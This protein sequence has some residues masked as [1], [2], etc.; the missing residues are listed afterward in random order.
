MSK[1]LF[2]KGLSDFLFENP[3]E[4]EMINTY[5]VDDDESEDSKAKTKYHLITNSKFAECYVIDKEN[6]LKYMLAFTT[7]KNIIN[8]YLDQLVGYN[9]KKYNLT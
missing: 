2:I 6:Y 1:G 8:K 4:Q 9:I 7:D 3:R 5:E